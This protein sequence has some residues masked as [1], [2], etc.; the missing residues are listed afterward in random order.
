MTFAVFHDFP[1]LENG[2]PNSM[3]FHDQGAP[4]TLG[5]PYLSTLWCQCYI[6]SKQELQENRYC[7]NIGKK[8]KAES[9]LRERTCRWAMEFTICTSTAAWTTRPTV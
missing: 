9:H 1:G 8:D 2:L 4:C 5:L 3:N 7:V 6:K